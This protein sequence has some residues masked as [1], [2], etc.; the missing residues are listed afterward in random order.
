MRFGIMCEGTTFPAWQARTI[1]RLLDVQGVELA[2]LLIDDRPAPPRAARHVALARLLG[3]GR[4]AWALFDRVAVRGRSAAMAPVDLARRLAGVPTRRCRV[5]VRGRFSEHFR[6]EDVA[7]VRD[8]GLDFVLRFAFGIIRGDMLAAPRHGVWSFHHDDPE[9]YRGTP[10]AFWEIADGDPL[11]GAVLQRLTERLD[12]GVILQQGWFATIDHSYVKNR[13]QVYFGGAEWPAR[14]CRDLLAG[15][16]PYVDAPPVRTTAPVRTAPGTAATLRATA[17]LMK[18]FIRYQAQ[19]LFR[20]DRWHVGV[21]D[22][23]IERFL[24][25]GAR[26]AVRWLPG[27]LRDGFLA[28]PFAVTRDGRLDVLAEAYDFRSGRGRLAALTLDGEGRSARLAPVLAR[29]VHLSYP[30]VIEHEGEVYCIPESA[31]ARDAVLYRADPF[32][33]GWR[34]VA[35]LVHDFPVIDPTLVFHGGLWWLFGT[36]GERG[37]QTHLHA[38]YAERLE[39]PYRPHASNPLKTDVR[40][41]R[42]AGTPF[43]RD[44]VLHRPAQDGTRG[45]GS[46]VVITRVDRLTPVAFAETVVA[47]VDPDPAGPYPDGLHTLAAAGDVTL[48]DGKR[49]AFSW[50]AFRRAFAEK[51][52]AARRRAAGYRAPALPDAEGARSR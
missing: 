48:V 30:F 50:P 17:I 16:A 49:L 42:P 4:L 6:A 9:R 1:E 43:V 24:E 47:R 44:G 51:A 21:A 11:T 13:D 22:A 25:G 12:G 14:V 15:A 36:D 5:E 23:P 27:P 8:A 35:T 34:R 52:R 33:T 2:L 3:S 18:N 46:A 29:D 20:T 32:P 41:A 31:E 10:P 37:P 26:P 28:D 7:A 38:W 40:S 39:G 45:Y 19:A